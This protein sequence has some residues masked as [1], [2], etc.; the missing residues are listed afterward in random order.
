VVAPVTQLASRPTTQPLSH[1]ETPQACARAFVFKTPFSIFDSL[2]PEMT[3][4]KPEATAATIDGMFSVVQVEYIPK[5]TITLP[6]GQEI[7]LPAEFFIPWEAVTEPVTFKSLA[8]V[9]P[10][11]FNV[12][13]V[14]WPLTVMSVEVTGPVMSTPV[15]V[16]SMEPPLATLVRVKVSN[17]IVVIISDLFFIYCPPGTLFVLFIK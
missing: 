3:S 11:I 2:T 5:S 6:G 14:E 9:W 4:G 7:S 17:I 10:V 12:V 13:V 1:L 16:M 15:V 8:V